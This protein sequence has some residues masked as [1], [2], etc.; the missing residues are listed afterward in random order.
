MLTGMAAWVIGR[1]VLHLETPYL[2]AVGLSALV[3]L[4]MAMLE[5]RGEA[6]AER[7]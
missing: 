6:A 4:G 5:R 2:T 3:Y 1:F 7:R